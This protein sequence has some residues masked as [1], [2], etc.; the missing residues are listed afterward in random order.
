M[1]NAW[2]TY[3][4]AWATLKDRPVLYF[5]TMPWPVLNQPTSTE[6]LTAN[7][8]GA[9]VLSPAHSTDKQNSQRL[10]DQLLRWHPDR[11]ESKWVPKANDAD[12]EAVRRGAGQVARAL[13]ELMARENGVFG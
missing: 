11:F 6:D 5:S 1:K 9:F 4:A 7:A 8:I 12:K 10:K 2:T 13:N 3:E